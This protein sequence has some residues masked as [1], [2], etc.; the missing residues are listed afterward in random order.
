MMGMLEYLVQRIS[1]TDVSAASN[2]HSRCVDDM[3]TV[4]IGCFLKLQCGHNNQYSAK[5][6]KEL[7]RLIQTACGEHIDT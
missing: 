3:D 6:R 1:S 5:E 4:S 2:W 7:M